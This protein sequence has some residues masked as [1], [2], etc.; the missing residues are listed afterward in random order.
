MSGKLKTTETKIFAFK[1]P[2]VNSH[3]TT[4]RDFEYNLPTELE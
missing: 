4:K 2:G 3:G 1:E